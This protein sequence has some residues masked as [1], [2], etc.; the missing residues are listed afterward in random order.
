MS[1]IDSSAALLLPLAALLTRAADTHDD[2]A[3]PLD[4]PPHDRLRA[5]LEPYFDDQPSELA[6]HV[7]LAAA[8][9][10][11]HVSE[12]SASSA[13]LSELA[14]RA[15]AK[16]FA[17]APPAEILARELVACCGES[18]SSFELLSRD[19]VQHT[20]RVCGLEPAKRPEL[21]A[22]FDELDNDD[23]TSIT[24]EQ[25]L[26]GMPRMVA[27]LL[28]AP[29]ATEKLPKSS[30][31][32]SKRSHRR[33]SSTSTSSSSNNNSSSSKD[34]DKEQ[35]KARRKA[36]KLEKEREAL[37]REQ[38]AIDAEL[39]QLSMERELILKDVNDWA[40]KGERRNSSKSRKEKK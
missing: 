23:D 5:F 29:V 32:T 35:E 16:R 17:S 28:G 1:T 7:R 6:R 13:S 39:A 27:L 20:F 34:K 25:F 3:L 40:K 11:Q 15:A 36:D 2:P 30:S 38:E 24:Q 9:C 18:K 8:V 33:N 10:E 26:E 21:N 31:G 4:Q 22:I 37:A 12:Q 19:N 14:A